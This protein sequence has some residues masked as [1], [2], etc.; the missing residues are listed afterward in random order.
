MF[1]THKYKYIIHKLKYKININKQIFKNIPDQIC[2]KISRD[3]CMCMALPEVSY[4][5]QGF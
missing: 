1:I 5:S 2:K 4:S 3:F